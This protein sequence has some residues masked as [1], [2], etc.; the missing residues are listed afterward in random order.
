MAERVIGVI[1][2]S[3]IYDLPG[4]EEVE[5]VALETPFGSPSDAYTTGRL[6]D[7]K[8]VFLARHGRGHRVL[9]HEINYRANIWGFKKL[10]VQW[11]L[12]LTAVG[13]M[14]EEIVPG[15]MVIVDQYF[16]RT[17]GRPSTFFGD[18]IAAHVGFGDPVS[19]KLAEVLHEA[20]VEAVAGTDVTVHKGGTYICMNG[21]QFSTRAESNIYRSWGVDVIGMTNMPEAKLARE[22][23]ISYAALA[24]ATDYDCWH[25]GHDDVSVDQVIAILK[26]NAENARKVVATAI[27]KV[28]AVH[29][30]IAAT[31]LENAI[32]TE[33][34]EIPADVKE[35]LEPIITKY[36]S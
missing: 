35:R 30:C 18:G 36:L 17:N 3:G 29:D 15:D 22:A 10:G 9:P 2:G 26:Q 16:D 28:P 11:L 33:L 8:L 12:S 20:A 34:S 6:G 24:L 27:P 25:E 13:S 1:G 23:E 21:P 4:L 14:R 7:A 32:M 5:H 31:A 19:P